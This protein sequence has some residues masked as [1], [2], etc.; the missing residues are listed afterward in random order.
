MAAEHIPTSL[1]QIEQ[2]LKIAAL[3]GGG[4]FFAWKLFTG[5][6][7]INLKL[8]LKLDR[9]AKSDEED[10]LGITVLFEKGTT[11]SIWLKRI[12]ARATWPGNQDPEPTDMSEELNWL[13][14][15]DGKI[16]WGQHETSNGTI[17][18]S[19]GESTTVARTTV[20][21]SQAAVTVEVAA[22]GRRNFWPRG[23]QWR[24]SA[25]SLPLPKQSTGKQ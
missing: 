17:A 23:F 5:W 2:W 18:L 7:I 9:A 10:H 20:V 16:T 8:S 15:H 25:V 13:G 22:F 19:P 1:D 21:P 4:I 6:L 3:A 11:D 24:A 12:S 14:I